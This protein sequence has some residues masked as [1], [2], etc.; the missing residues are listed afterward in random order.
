[1][2]KFLGLMVIIYIVFFIIINVNA[3]NMNNDENIIEDLISKYN[4]VT[5]GQNIPSDTAWYEIDYPKGTV[6]K[7][8]H[9]VGPILVEGNLGTNESQSIDHSQQ[10]YGISSYIQNKIIASGHAGSSSTYDDT[11]LYVGVDNVVERYCEIYNWGCNEENMNQYRINGKEYYTRYETIKD[12]NEDKYLDFNKLYEK[13]INEQ[14]KLSSGTIIESSDDIYL[15]SGGTYTIESVID[16]NNIH[17]T[18]YNKDE[19][20]LININ[21]DGVIERFPKILIGD[22]EV[23]TEDY[24]YRNGS[25]EKYFGNIVFNLPYAKK[26][27][28]AKAPFIGHFIAPNTDVEM[29]EMNFAGAFIVNSLTGSGNTEGHMYPYSLSELPKDEQNSNENSSSNSNSNSH[30]E[31]VKGDTE[32]N[33]ETLDNITLVIASLIL[34]TIM[35]TVSIK[36]ILKYK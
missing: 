27:T 23:S 25:T 28:L 16:V 14:K 4:V 32:E 13:V 22:S 2:K 20:T 30:E 34:S 3:V 11:K 19:I 29:P 26:V 5:L 7:L 24:I 15:K 36:G 17:I 31:G 33:P 10:T 1:M 12:T 8:I 9:I 18:D 21:D 6:S 35:I